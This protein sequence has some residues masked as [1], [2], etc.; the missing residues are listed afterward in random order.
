MCNIAKTAYPTSDDK[1]YADKKYDQLLSLSLAYIE[2]W[3]I[4]TYVECSTDGTYTLINFYFCFEQINT[5]TLA[6]R[7]CVS[8]NTAK[9]EI[10]VVGLYDCTMIVLATLLIIINKLMSLWEANFEIK[11]SKMERN[12]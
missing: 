4:I 12:K 5:I 10:L 2:L 8:R 6:D 9:H 7:C 3:I 1:F 11:N